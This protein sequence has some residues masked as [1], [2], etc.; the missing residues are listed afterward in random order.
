MQRYKR[1]EVMAQWKKGLGRTYERD[2]D[3]WPIKLIPDP[4]HQPAD[5]ATK[6]ARTGQPWTDEEHSQLCAE[7]AQCLDWDTIGATHL[8]QALAVWSRAHDRGLIPYGSPPPGE[9]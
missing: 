8:R 7:V 5:P 3:G 9:L 1:H 6:S 2:G 4:V